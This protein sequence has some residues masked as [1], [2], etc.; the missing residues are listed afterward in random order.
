VS[1]IEFSRNGTTF[2][3]VGTSGGMFSVTQGDYLRVTYTA[4][5]TLTLVPR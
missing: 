3:P 4:A 1:L 5:P 2:F